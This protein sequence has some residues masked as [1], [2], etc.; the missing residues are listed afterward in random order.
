M[1]HWKRILS[2]LLVFCLLLGIS[3]G[4]A[5]RR[6]DPGEPLGADAYLEADAVFARLDAMNTRS[7]PITAARVYNAV[8]GMAEVLPGSVE[9]QGSSRVVWTTTDGISCVWSDYYTDIARRCTLPAQEPEAPVE[10]QAITHGKDVYLIEPYFGID[11]NFTGQYQQEA[12]DLARA[13]GGHYFLRSTKYATIDK[14]AQALENGGLIIFDSHG[15][16]DYKN[17]ADCTSGATTSYLCL[18]TREGITQADYQDRHV[19]YS[20][21]GGIVFCEVDGTAIANHMTKDAGNS[22][23]WAAICLGMATD[24]LCGPLLEKGVN[25]MYGYSQT[26]SFAGDYLYEAAFFDSLAAGK[27]VA[28]SAADMKER[29]GFWDYAPQMGLGGGYTTIE[30]ARAGRCAFPVVA[31][32]QDPYPENADDLQEVRSQWRLV[33]F[34]CP[35]SRTELRDAVEPSCF[36]PGWTGDTWCLAC[37]E[38]IAQGSV[39]EP[40]SEN[41]PLAGFGD[42]NPGSW[43]HEALEYALLHGL[44]QGRSATVFAPKDTMTRAELA[45]VLYN[46]AGKPAHGDAAAFND[47]PAASWA[48]DAVCWAAETGIVAGDGNGSFMPKN[49]VTRETLALMLYRYAQGEAKDIGVLERFHDGYDTHSWAAQGTAWAIEQGVLAGYTDGT[50]LPRKAV[51]RAEAAQMLM[52]F[53]A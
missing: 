38:R 28:A 24:G 6:Q 43:Y 2:F 36:L 46:M 39:L 33:E 25:T 19:N 22:M 26:V 23:I 3:A 35:H 9:Y 41:C 34:A 49:T 7:A 14:V 52:N 42:V 16:T 21:T 17:G 32:P 48:Y 47:V 15:N 12:M 4:A 40:S 18:S 53:L 8:S 45:A 29:W 5:G 30:A 13:I 11:Q 37:G 1:L 27:D 10:P 50:L 31:S 20:T 51:T 44:M